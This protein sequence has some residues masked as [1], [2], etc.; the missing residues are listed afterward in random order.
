MMAYMNRHEREVR[1]AL[2]LGK[3]DAALRARHRSRLACMQHERLVH[4]L[5]MLAV[6]LYACLFFLAVLIVPSDLLWAVAAILIVLEIAYILHYFR[7]ENAVQRWY[8]LADDIE[9]RPAPAAGDA[10]D[11]A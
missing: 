11:G 9:E 6:G 7:L 1:E 4:L 3:V 10:P 5:V 8:R 2:R